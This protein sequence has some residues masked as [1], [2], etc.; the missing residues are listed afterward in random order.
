VIEEG[1]VGFGD[2]AGLVGKVDRRNL[3]TGDSERRE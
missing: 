3:R 1:Q 2:G